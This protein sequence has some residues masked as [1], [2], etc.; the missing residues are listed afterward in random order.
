[1]T[2]QAGYDVCASMRKLSWTHYTPTQ[3]SH[4]THFE[5]DDVLGAVRAHY[6]E[7]SA[8][9]EAL[10]ADISADVEALLA[11]LRADWAETDAE[12]AIIFADINADVEALLASLRADWAI[13]S[14]GDGPATTI[15]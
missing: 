12:L 15:L 7:D 9:V 3:D 1:A 4:M 13:E 2:D 5:T 10:L 14:P 8:D 11:S 6:A